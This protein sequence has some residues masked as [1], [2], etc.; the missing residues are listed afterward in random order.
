[1]IGKGEEVFEKGRGYCRGGESQ[2]GRKGG[3]EKTNKMISGEES[4]P[5]EKRIKGKV[6]EKS[7]ARK[8]KK[9]EGGD[10]MLQEKNAL[11]GVR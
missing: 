6:A 10:G 5:E 7:R 9:G 4:S 2:K 1:V 8:V 11:E 3:E